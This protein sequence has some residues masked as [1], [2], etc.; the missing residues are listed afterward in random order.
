MSWRNY[1]E[2]AYWFVHSPRWRAW[3]VG[4]FMLSQV[5]VNFW[6]ASKIERLSH[7]GRRDTRHDHW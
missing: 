3:M 1:V 2:K 6:I 5:Y 7:A 4:L